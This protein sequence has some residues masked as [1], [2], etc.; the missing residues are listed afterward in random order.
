VF[1]YRA[2]DLPSKLPGL[3]EAPAQVKDPVVPGELRRSS[4][5]AEVVRPN[6]D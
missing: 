2:I 6:R 1:N 4:S 3:G 5:P